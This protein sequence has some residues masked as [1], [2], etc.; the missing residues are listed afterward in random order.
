MKTSNRAASGASL[1]LGA[2]AAAIAVMSPAYAQDNESDDRIVVT[3]T[4]IA[5]DPNLTEPLPVQSI[6]A[7]QIRFSGQQDITEV[8][9]DVP[10]LLTTT[11]AENS[12]NGVFS[13]AVGASSLNLRG[14]G[15]ERTLVLVN[16]RRHVSG[17]A[18]ANIVDVNTIPNALVERVDVL[19]GGASQVYGADA[20]TGV[21]NFILKRDFEGLDLSVN[22][23]ISGQ[24]DG[25]RYGFSGV[26]GKNLFDDRFNV[27]VSLDYSKRQE[28]L[29]GD[30]DF[31]RNNRIADDLPNPA[32]RFQNGDITSATPNF[33]RFY[34]PSTF[35][36]TSDAPCNRYG[37]D[38][39]FGFYET[40][41]PILSQA[42]FLNLYAQAFPG[43]PVPTL[44][45]AELS[46]ID[47]AQNSPARLIAS[48]PRFSISSNS[49]VILPGSLFFP[50]LDLDSNGA[51][52]CLQSFVGAQSTFDL[53]PP[54]IGFAG[55]C[56]TI[57]ANGN[58]VPYQDGQISGEFNQFGGDGIPNTFNQDYLTPDIENV[59]GNIFL[60]YELADGVDWIFEGKI[61]DTTAT[62][63]GP[64][65][66][67]W[68]LLTVE[69]DNPYIPSALSPIAADG[70]F[71]TRDPTDLGAN[72][73]QEK[74]RTY[75]FVT[76]IEAETANGFKY[77]LTVNWGRFEREAINNNRVIVDR[78]FAAVD[79]T[80]DASGNPICRSDIDP[81]A[82]PT[83]PFGIPSFDPGFF[84]F[85]PGD[86]QCRP[87]NVFGRGFGDQTQAAVDFITTTTINEFALEQFVVGGSVV[88]DLDAWLTL[89]GGSIGF[90]TGFEYREERSTST[91]DALVRGVLPVDTPDGNAGDLI[92][93]LPNDQNS[94]VFDPGAIINNEQGKFDV[95]EYFLEASLPIIQ[96]RPFFDE[97]TVQG[98]A[99]FASYSTIGATLS[100]GVSGTWAPIEDIRFRASY[101]EP[102]RA[103]NITELFAPS[104]A[105]FFRPDDPCD[106]SQIDAL[107]TAGDPRGAVRE[108]NCRADGIPVGFTDPLSARFVGETVGNSALAEEK[109]QTFSVGAVVQPRF[110]E[111]LAVTVDYW[112]IQIDQAISS[113]SAQDIV[114]GCYDSA[115]FAA[116]VA[117]QFCDL[118]TRN[119]D[120]TSPQFN[121]FNFLRQQELNF[122]S[123][124]ARGIDA[125]VSYDFEIG[126]SDFNITVNGAWMERL[127][128]FFN[129]ADPTAVDPELGEIQRPEFAAN[130]FFNYRR[131]PFAFTWQTQFQDEQGL[132]AVEI[133]TVN[134]NY[135][136]AGI[137]DAVFIHDVNA[138]YQISDQLQVYGGINNVL[139]RNPFFTEQAYPVSPLGRYFFLGARFTM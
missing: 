32:L 107:I 114:D 83:T 19:T 16:G 103:P 35:I 29:F 87:Y 130:G 63:G 3:G 50:G 75:R 106:Q 116:G 131:G 113:P 111:G 11:T 139:D 59:V 48:D 57:D 18:G 53:S 4:R 65:N 137:A 60:T 24:G 8:I 74:R 84:T 109:A 25:E 95:W 34:D 66:T 133:E 70:F 56:Y 129:P 132:R 77:D 120:P 126:R 62:F 22:G 136:P 54:L 49:G 42:N 88:G 21:V 102:I 47:R 28:I 51:D 127:N 123:L 125:Q 43:D 12:L 2:S 135:G 112:S 46:L 86:G 68:D 9:N 41:L 72:I 69:P 38:A 97:L 115:G 17:V 26:A 13:D 94:L 33:A 96:D 100:W 58:P 76:G 138:S 15:E 14:L 91:F 92:R 45:S 93:D 73:D 82:P 105:A 117:N 71:V 89:P 78:F 108:A 40:G 122:A 5:R 10:A 104:Q 124:D 99:R 61:A 98:G 119:D 67:F 7:D 37:I 39:C 30:R 85:N 64:L 23:G 128:Q 52:D 36:A 110:I 27:T 44:T 121:G 118:F 79:A 1:F 134:T 101:A 31:S 90:A 20:V 55:G 80:T 81:T 6:G